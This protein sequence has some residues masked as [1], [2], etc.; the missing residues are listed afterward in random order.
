MTWFPETRHAW[1]RNK[2]LR[3]E[4]LVISMLK[5]DHS[6]GYRDRAFEIAD[7]IQQFREMYY[8]AGR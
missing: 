1:R 2:L 6:G 4:L 5:G 8:P 7:L 3:A